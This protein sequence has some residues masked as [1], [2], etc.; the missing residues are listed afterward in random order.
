[1]RTRGS[2]MGLHESENLTRKRRRLGRLRAPCRLLGVTLAVAMV[3]AACGSTSASVS[4]KGPITVAAFNAFEGSEAAEGP[5]KEAECYAAE[6]EVNNG[7]GILGRKLQCVPFDSTSDPA[8]A[9]PNATHMLSKAKNLVLVDGPGT[10]EPATDSII[11]P[12]HVLEFSWDAGPIYDHQTNPLWFRFY[13]A[14][15]LAG[16]GEAAYLMKHGYTH[17]AGVFDT[18][19]GAQAQVPNLVK[20]YAKLGGKLAIDLKLAPGN[21][22]RT[23]VSQLLQ[24]HPDAIITELDTPQETTAFFSELAQLSGGKIPPIIATQGEVDSATNWPQ[25]VT[26]AIGVAAAHRMV[27][28]AAGGGI[29]PVGYATVKHSLLTA[30]EK[31]VDRQ[32]YIGSWSAASGCDAVAIMALAIDQTKSTDP[33]KLA[34]VIDRI[35]NGVP[36]AVVVHNYAQGRKEIAAGH[37]IRFVGGA[38]PLTFNKYHNLVV[39]FQLLRWEGTKAGWVPLP[40]DTLT[41]A[42]ILKLT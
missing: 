1:M 39:P 13:P 30:P 32:Q 16:I 17:A 26:K 36:G 18:S 3:V 8:D 40:K 29:D 21:T 12:A 15:S 23:E 24:S 5:K 10:E 2:E 31:I 28:I 19:P 27:E 11:R 37:Q 35:A 9:V 22:Y 20:T 4:K 42:A 38:G 25:L 14:D 41:P 6:T 7:G 33:S 34:P